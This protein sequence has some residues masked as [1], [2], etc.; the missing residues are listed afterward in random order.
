MSS[1]VNSG[2]EGAKYRSFCSFSPRQ[3]AGSRVKR[4]AERAPGS[5]PATTS[6]IT[7][8]LVAS[9]SA[10]VAA[11]TRTSACTDRPPEVVIAAMLGT[12]RAKAPSHRRTGA[13]SLSSTI[14]RQDKTDSSD[15]R[16]IFASRGF[17]RDFPSTGCAK[18][19][20]P[21]GPRVGILSTGQI[22]C[23]CDLYSEKTTTRSPAEAL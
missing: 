11:L 20:I 23:P 14:H 3:H 18:N 21:S 12:T 13:S 10:L 15:L 7:F 4:T 19:Q 2:A 6:C 5:A 17:G 9:H 1:S 16:D 8:R 22:A